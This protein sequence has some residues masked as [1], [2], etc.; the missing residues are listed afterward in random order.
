MGKRLG[1][2]ARGAN[3]ASSRKD[4]DR[5]LRRWTLGLS[6]FA[7]LLAGPRAGAQQPADEVESAEAPGIPYVVLVGIDKYPDPQIIPRA[8]A[9]DD[10]KALYD[11]FTNKA[12]LGAR[13][14]NV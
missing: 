14:K 12:H 1:L 2:T 3:G 4:R 6:L 9:E 8:H 7:L 13:A 5:M 10:A 11:L